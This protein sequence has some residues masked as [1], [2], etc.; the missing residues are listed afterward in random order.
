MTTSTPQNITLFKPLPKANRIKLAIPYCMKVEREAF[1]RLDTSFYHPNQ[2]LWSIYNT[3][4]NLKKVEALFGK[5]LKTVDTGT[6]KQMPQ[7]TLSET[8]EAELARTYQKMV[9][10]GMS[11]NTIK[12]YCSSLKTFFHYFKLQAL[13][14]VTKEQIEGYVFELIMKYKISESTQNGII[15]AI[16]CYY[17]KVLEQPR[18]YYNIT[19]PRKSL[20]L[21]N[22]LSAQE[23]K[24]II[25][26]PENLKHKAIL[27]VIYAAGLRMSELLN[28]RVYD[29]RSD[30][31]YI[32][33][34]DSK[35]NKDRHTVLSE[36]LLT[37]LRS[38]YREFKPA[39][40]LFEGQTGGQ[41]SATSVQSIYRKAV[42]D[43]NSNPWSTP[44]TLRHSFATHLMLSGASSRS[45]QAALGHSS[46]ETT[47][48]YTHVLSTNNKTM[49]SPLDL[50]YEKSTFEKSDNGMLI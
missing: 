23:V 4:E 12:T 19:R 47:E 41:Y 44:H 27:H 3:E 22:V 36:N 2:K 7:I 49:K 6:P 17:E 32:F 48:I 14:T 30:D 5:S 29:I 20:N 50:L 25:N 37:M 11:Q 9:L 28:L 45:I 39:Y 1:K 18:E 35:G 42:K 13:P 43:T 46:L 33:V 15:N 31:G 8:S 16:K 10:K 26:S 21:P 34:K 40:W 38:Y 24:A